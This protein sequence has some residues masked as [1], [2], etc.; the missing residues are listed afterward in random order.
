MNEI[1]AARRENR[2]EAGAGSSLTIAVDDS[3]PTASWSVDVYAKL[4]LIDGE[5][6]LGRVITTPFVGAAPPSR[7]I[8][9]ASVPGAVG[10]AVSFR[11]NAGPA[12]STAGVALA[13]AECCSDAGLRP[14]FPLEV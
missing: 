13:V 10:W 1:L 4:P 6:W 14:I 3:E 9:I 5:R 2:F 7:I 12:T 11:L 8:A